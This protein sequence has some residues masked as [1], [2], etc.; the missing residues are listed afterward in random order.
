[1]F[2]LLL[3]I[4]ITLCYLSSATALTMTIEDTSPIFSYSPEWSPGDSSQDDSASQY[5]SSTFMATNSMGATMSFTFNGSTIA[6]FGYWCD[7]C[8]SWVLNQIV[9]RAD[10][11]SPQIKMDGDFVTE[12]DGHADPDQFQQQLFSADDLDAGLHTVELTNLEQK[13]VDVDYITC[14]SSMGDNSEG[15]DDLVQTYQDTD[16]AFTY[17]SSWSTKVSN[18]GT[19]LGGTGHTTSTTGSTAHFTFTGAGVTLYGPVGPSYGSYSALLDGIPIN[20]ENGTQLAHTSNANEL[21]AFSANKTR[22]SA[23][24][25]LFHASGLANGEHVLDIVA[26]SD[27]GIAVD[28]ALTYIPKGGDGR[29]LMHNIPARLSKGAIAGVV[30]GSVGTLTLVLLALYWM[31]I[32]NRGGNLGRRPTFG[33]DITSNNEKDGHI[34][35]VFDWSRSTKRTSVDSWMS[36]AAPPAVITVTASTPF[37]GN[38]VPSPYPYTNPTLN[39][40]QSINHAGPPNSFRGPQGYASTPASTINRSPSGRSIPEGGV[41]NP[42]SMGAQ[43]LGSMGSSKELEAAGVLNGFG[44]VGSSNGFGSAGSAKELEAAVGSYQSAGIGARVST[45]PPD[46]RQATQVYRG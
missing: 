9:D 43:N 8:A 10:R 23:T 41:Q 15:Q 21:G 37:P 4:F 13:F 42:G 40:T 19:F 26:E 11:R 12:Q 27:E 36:G 28:F 20:S 45:L 16:D 1:M 29:G 22:A 39:Y 30:I 32:R 6:I 14:T 33:R 38:A 44:S 18:A 24:Q 25:V 5:S 17:D 7:W 34:L 46:Y 3:L 2:N 31:F 35:P